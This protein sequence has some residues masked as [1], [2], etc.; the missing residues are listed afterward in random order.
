M[1]ILAFYVNFTF[2]KCAQDSVFLVFHV[3][4]SG[5]CTFLPF[6]SR[7]YAN[8]IGNTA[9]QLLKLFGNCLALYFGANVRSFLLLF[10]DYAGICDMLELAGVFMK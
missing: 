9:Y 7:Q 6:S 4:A 1:F 8:R 5:L 3:C 10:S 2:R